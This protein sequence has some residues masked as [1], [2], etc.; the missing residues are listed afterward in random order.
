MPS[1]AVRRRSIAPVSALT[2]ACWLERGNGRL[3]DTTRERPRLRSDRE[4][5]FRLQ[6]LVRRYTSLVLDRTQT[7]PPARRAPRPLV[8][9]E[10]DH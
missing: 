10:S 9:V 8:S 3:H 1:A 2:G 6:P 4:E 5:R 7:A